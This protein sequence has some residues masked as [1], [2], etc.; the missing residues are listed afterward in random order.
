MSALRGMFSSSGRRA[1]Y[2]TDTADTTYM[3]DEYRLLSGNNSNQRIPW[4]HDDRWWVRWP[5]FL[6]LSFWHGVVN[7]FTTLRMSARRVALQVARAWRYVSPYLLGDFVHLFLVFALLGIL[8]G[9]QRSTPTL[10]FAWNCLALPGL[11]A[12]LNSSAEHFIWLLPEAMLEVRSEILPNLLTLIVS[13]FVENSLPLLLI[14]LSLG[15]Q[16]YT[17]KILTLLSHSSWVAW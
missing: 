5:A 17:F 10:T 11:D 9:F 14:D 1:T 3:G 15:S 13:Q 6:A 4:H 7:A 8:S 2:T 16:Q 12:F